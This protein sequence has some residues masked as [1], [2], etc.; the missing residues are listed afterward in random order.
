M[1]KVTKTRLKGSIL[2]ILALLYCYGSVLRVGFNIYYFPEV[3][4]S[5]LNFHILSSGLV[6][7]YFMCV[8]VAGSFKLKK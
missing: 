7:L 6:S 2:F 5:Y 8:I 3:D 1:K 4:H